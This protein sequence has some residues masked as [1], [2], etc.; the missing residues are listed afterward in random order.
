MGFQKTTFIAIWLSRQSSSYCAYVS[1]IQTIPFFRVF[2]DDESLFPEL[3]TPWLFY[4]LG[5]YAWSDNSALNFLYW[6]PGEPSQLGV[7]HEIEECV[8]FNRVAQK[9]NDISCFSQRGYVCKAVK[10][11]WEYMFL[12]PRK[13]QGSR[14]PIIGPVISQKKKSNCL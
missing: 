3:I 11:N 6:N 4:S 8:E 14:S 1:F 10:G 2:H 12:Y 9:W 7:H 13:G 5:S